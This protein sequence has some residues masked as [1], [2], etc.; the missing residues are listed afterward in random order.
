MSSCA[1]PRRDISNGT[2]RTS[3]LIRSAAIRVYSGLSRVFMTLSE[4]WGKGLTPRL[5]PRALPLKWQSSCREKNLALARFS[6]DLGPLNGVRTAQARAHPHSDYTN[7]VQP[8]CSPSLA[9]KQPGPAALRF[10]VCGLVQGV[11]FRPFVYRLALRCGLAGRVFNDPAGVCIEVE[12]QAAA[13][14]QFRRLLSAEVPPAA[15][16]D[17]I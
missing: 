1:A 8:Q 4:T 2:A 16:V 12:G 14:E 6:A 11:G 13:L 3:R 10:V 9:E 17:S 7:Q 5:R 15:H